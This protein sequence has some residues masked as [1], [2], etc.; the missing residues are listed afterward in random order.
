MVDYPSRSP[1][2]HYYGQSTAGPS[3]ND[4]RLTHSSAHRSSTNAGF[5][6]S[7]SARTTYASYQSQPDAWEANYLS[8]VDDFKLFSFGRPDVDQGDERWKI[9][10]REGDETSSSSSDDSESRRRPRGRSRDITPRASVVSLDVSASRSG[11]RPRSHPSQLQQ[12]NYY[13][14]GTG[15]SGNEDRENSHHYKYHHH[16]FELLDEHNHGEEMPA[17]VRSDFSIYS[18]DTGYDAASSYR[19]RSGTGSYAPSYTS[20]HARDRAEAEAEAISI[21]SSRP[22]SSAASGLALASSLDGDRH[23][24]P[25][26]LSISSTRRSLS[27]DEQYEHHGEGGELYDT[28]HLSNSDSE[29]ISLESATSSNMHLSVSSLRFDEER[30]FTLEQNEQAKNFAAPPNHMT[31]MSV[32]NLTWNQNAPSAPVPMTRLRSLSRSSSPSPSL[33]SASS[34]SAA[35]NALADFDFTYIT[36]GL[37]FSANAMSQTSYMPH[38]TSEEKLDFVRSR[39]NVHHDDGA[40]G[41]RTE[42]KRSL[43]VERGVPMGWVDDFSI[44][45]TPFNNTNTERKRA[46]AVTVTAADGGASSTLPHTSAGTVSSSGTGRS[47]YGLSDIAN[48]KDTKPQSRSPSQSRD[49]HSSTSPY[50]DLTALLDHSEINSTNGM[51]NVAQL[52]ASSPSAPPNAVRRKRS[53]FA[54]L[55]ALAI[56]SMNSNS[57]TKET[58]ATLLQPISPL[59][60]ALPV[61]PARTIKGEIQRTDVGLE[62]HNAEPSPDCRE[63][64]HQQQS[65]RQN[66]QLLRRQIPI[67]YLRFHLCL[68]LPPLIHPYPMDPPFIF[69]P[70]LLQSHPL[71]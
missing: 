13:H 62:K 40:G 34:S 33:S 17:G 31:D 71:L 24:H 47:K 59:S 35:H 67:L 61:S 5:W 39:S 11:I 3:S 68:C 10:T 52:H 56:G 43:R 51:P 19:S 60:P 50:K 53:A 64:K 22:A 1:Q 7:T 58:Q 69:R 20:S 32:S 38:S 12:I 46:R 49:T 15:D 66:Y 36:S 23:Y 6:S 55:G 63:T 45:T 4:S 21:S 44:P 27:F 42:G 41:V 16:P 14:R 26:D 48:S 2:T 65:I 25:D 29:R 28:P 57:R 30:D 70:T 37:A 9:T 8:T 18:Y 54:S